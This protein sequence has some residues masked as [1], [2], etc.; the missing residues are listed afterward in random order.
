MST[1]QQR[2]EWLTLEEAA[3]KFGRSVS[4]IRNY[5]S[6]GHIKRYKKPLDKRV[7]VRPDEIEAAINQPPQLDEH[8]SGKG[9]KR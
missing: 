7:Y 4:T 2:E 6:G 3:A 8:A 9:D 1:T 5:I